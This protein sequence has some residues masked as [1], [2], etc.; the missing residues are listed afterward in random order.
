MN[1]NKNI[2]FKRPLY[3]AYIV[4][5]NMKHKGYS[6]HELGLSLV[7]GTLDN[8]EDSKKCFDEK[9]FDP[10]EYLTSTPE[11][12]NQC[13]EMQFYESLFEHFSEDEIIKISSFI[14][15][16]YSPESFIKFAFEPVTSMDMNT[17]PL[18]RVPCDSC[19]GMFQLQQYDEDF[20]VLPFA[21][22]L[23]FH[24]CEE[25]WAKAAKLQKTNLK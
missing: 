4:A 17:Y 19:R 15:K 20:T 18:H 9:R 21:I 7:G 23:C 2:Q 12:N 8:W 5:K 22:Y 13:D 24:I 11:F 10:K 16:H 25:E 3:R 14:L 1:Q 6:F